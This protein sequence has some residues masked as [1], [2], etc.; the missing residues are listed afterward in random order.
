MSTES[1]Y[2]KASEA[3]ALK[4]HCINQ[5]D[6]CRYTAVTFYEWSLICYERPLLASLAGEYNNLLHRFDLLLQASLFDATDARTILCELDD[7]RKRSPATPDIFYREACRKL[8]K[9][10]TAITLKELHRKN[11]KTSSG[12]ETPAD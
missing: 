1:N 5:R 9:Q 11:H 4:T 3:A 2:P 7:L 6:N 8:D 12:D 10:A